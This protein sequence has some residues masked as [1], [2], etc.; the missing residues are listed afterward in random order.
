VFKTRYD[1]LLYA[2][3]EPGDDCIL[4]PSDWATIKGYGS[5]WVPHERTARKAH[6][7]AL[8]TVSEPPSA[9]HDAAHGPCNNR[10]CINPRHL[11]W[12][13][14]STNILHKKRDGTFNPPPQRTKLT[15]QDYEDIRNADGNHADI[16]KRYGVARSTIG[17]IKNY[18]GCYSCSKES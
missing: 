15:E 14:R 4:W 5:V 13:T 7:A 17:N 18:K 3:R 6:N 10:L 8:R 16:A 9:L 2:I 12:E 1:W 11:S